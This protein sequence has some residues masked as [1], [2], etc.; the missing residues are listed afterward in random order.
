MMLFRRLFKQSLKHKHAIIVI[1]VV[2]VVLLWWRMTRETFADEA[3]LCRGVYFKEIPGFL[4]PKQCDE[5]VAAAEARGL[6]AS[7]VG[8]LEDGRLDL[9]VR[10]SKQTWFAPGEHH[11][12]DL[13]RRKT[14]AL[15][16]ETG[17]ISKYR[18]E[19]VQVARYGTGGKYDSHYDGD[20]CGEGVGA[21][22]ADQ[23]LTT[24]LV[25]LSKPDKG[26]QTD[27]PLLGQSVTPEKGKALFFW[28]ADPKSRELFEKTLHAGTPVQSGVKW[29]AN[30]WTRAES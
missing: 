9:S 6:R 3:V 19:D 15:L 14:A 11:I 28:V 8:G 22:P 30:Q 27:F 2:V 20:D 23:R 16:A 12:S 25:Y 24:L 26:G 10:R 18:F 17:C 1:V 29:I 13:I 7:E 5:L 4:N 21:C